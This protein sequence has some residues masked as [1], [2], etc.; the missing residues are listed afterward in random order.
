MKNSLLLAR[1]RGIPISVHWTFILLIGWILVVSSQATGN[2]LSAAWSVLFVLSIFGCV[3]LHE[4]GHALVAQHFGIK[5]RSITLYPIGGIA[6]LETIPKRPREELLISV[7]GPVV[8]I[9]IA[10]IV[11]PFT[12]F[13]DLTNINALTITSL[14]TFLQAFVV[15]NM[16]LSVFN[17]IPSFPMDGGRVFR[18]L[19]SFKMNREKATRIA[20][21]VGQVFAVG[22]IFIGVY[23]NLMLVL[24]GLFVLF[25]SQAE[26]NYVKL[27][28]LLANKPLAMVTMHNIPTLAL[29]SSLKEAVK[30]TLDSQ[31]K[32]FLVMDQT[33][34]AG[35][36]NHNQLVSALGE[37]EETLLID[38]VIDQD[39][40][41]LSSQLQIEEALLTMQR[42]NKSM[43]VVMNGND[44]I[45]VVDNENLTEFIEIQNA[46]EKFAAKHHQ[47]NS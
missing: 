28:A 12:N 47:E 42:E 40:L 24:I 9:I 29:G 25:Q 26:L 3:I 34:I 13:S 5:T 14:S 18:A 16:V 35:T 20:V 22:F 38:E 46:K 27:E 39:V 11:F 17:L 37:K 1:V 36:L 2:I 44:R 45:G 31:H 32:N 33:R 10:G 15:A 41:Y 23:T 43:A 21:A 30:Q 19:L 4:L 8:N 6:Q 7:A